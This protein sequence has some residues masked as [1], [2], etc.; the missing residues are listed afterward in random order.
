MIS[1]R[2]LFQAA[3]LTGAGAVLLSGNAMEFQLGK[4]DATPEKVQIRLCDYVANV[5]KPPES[6]GHV[7]LIPNWGMM[8]NNKI[9]CCVFSGAGH[10]HL[11]WSAEG[12]HPAQFT[13]Q[14]IIQA[15]SAVTGYDPAQDSPF[16]NPTDRGANVSEA[17]KW[18]RTVGMADSVGNP[19][20]IEAYARIAPEADKIAQ[21]A[22]LFSAVGVGIQFPAFAMTQFKTGL[23]WDLSTTNTAIQGGHYI[24]IC[25]FTEDMLICVT[26]G[27]LQL[28][29][30]RF[31]DRYC[32]E[33]YAIFDSEYFVKGRSP[34]GF[35]QE[36]LL[37]D[38]GAMTA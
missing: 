20:Q 22:W 30:E 23:P 4:L 28:M 14:N 1:R 13:D 2:H 6:F 29:T 25:G 11:L 12:G 36:A 31:L 10:E 18:R 32:D 35:D 27:K 15:Y 24:P 38:L 37:S 19:H 16:G 17:L 8:M 33:A 7:G 9:G 34:E 21:A 3:A 5:P 26:W